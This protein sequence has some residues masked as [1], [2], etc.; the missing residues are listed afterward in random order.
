VFRSCSDLYTDVPALDLTAPLQWDVDP[1][2]GSLARYV[3]PASVCLQVSEWAGLHGQWAPHLRLLRAVPLSFYRLIIHPILANV[4]GCTLISRRARHRVHPT[5]L[6]LTRSPRKGPSLVTAIM[7]FRFRRR[8]AKREA[9]D[10]HP[11]LRPSPISQASA[12]VEETLVFLRNSADF[13]PPLKSAAAAAHHIWM[14]A[15]VLSPMCSSLLPTAETLSP[16]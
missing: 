7:P 2:H 1:T 6:F 15:K 5:T 11:A 10:E 8:R 3:D 12:H 4:T 9:P 13:F 14:I 16:R